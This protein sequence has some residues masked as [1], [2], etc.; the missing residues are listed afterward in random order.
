MVVEDEHILGHESSGIVVKAHE[1]V[2]NVR[3][4]DR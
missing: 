4:G 3:V 1:T 2:K